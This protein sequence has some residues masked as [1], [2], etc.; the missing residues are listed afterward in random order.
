[1]K[2]D[3]PRMAIVAAGVALSL[4]VLGAAC[5]FFEDDRSSD[6]PG[7]RRLSIEALKGAEYYDAQLARFFYF[8]N[9]EHVP[10]VQVPVQR[11]YSF[12]LPKGDDLV[13][14]GDLD[15]DGDEDAVVLV[16]MFIGASSQIPHLVVLSNDAGSPAYKAAITLR[17]NTFLES[18]DILSGVIEAEGVALGPR[19][20]HCCPSVP[21]TFRFRLV[22][23]ELI[24]E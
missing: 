1:M 16:T 20:A 5:S 6:A 24:A 18:L 23:G 4:A 13:A 3:Q 15:G 12:G 10:P 2:I 19:D 17:D 9:E 8:V 22:S 11:K 14:W 21:T 7:T